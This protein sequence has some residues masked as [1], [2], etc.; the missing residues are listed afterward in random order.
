MT[1][2]VKKKAGHGAL[3]PQ[4]A[5]SHCR[6]RVRTQSARS[7]RRTVSDPEPWR[8]ERGFAF[9]LSYPILS[10]SKTKTLPHWLSS[11][12]SAPYWS[13][14]P[15]ISHWLPSPI[16]C[17]LSASPRTSRRDRTT[18]R[19]SKY[20]GVTHASRIPGSILHLPPSSPLSIPRPP[21]LDLTSRTLTRGPKS[22]PPLALPPASVERCCSAW[23]ATSRRLRRCRPPLSLPEF[24]KEKQIAD[25]ILIFFLSNPAFDC[26]QCPR[27]STGH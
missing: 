1:T 19:G 20:R 21:H 27:C 2:A 18:S 17:R 8:K 7:N 22:H 24:E 11:T 9:W 4:D 3:I 14:G 26:S 10:R 25:S 6:R 5:P 13:T 15:F 12:N 16:S 23:L